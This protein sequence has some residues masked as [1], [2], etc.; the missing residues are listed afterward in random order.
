MNSWG[1]HLAHP[2]DTFAYQA[3]CIPGIHNSNNRGPNVMTRHL[4]AG[5][6]FSVQVDTCGSYVQQVVEH[7]FPSGR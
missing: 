1:S 7:A 2:P 4:G 5:I 6:L 3:F